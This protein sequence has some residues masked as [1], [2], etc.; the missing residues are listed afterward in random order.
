ML[1]SEKIGLVE[2]Y[3]SRY[4]AFD[5][6]GMLALLDEDVVFENESNGEITA[7]SDGKAEFE[8]L[9]SESVK[10]FSVRQQVV[11]AIEM[12]E[13]A[14]TVSIDYTGTLAIDL[15]NGLRAG[16]VLELKGQTYFEFQNGK[17][18]HI[19]DVS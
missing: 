6:S 3:V 8:S 12:F 4:N 13:R 14:A 17:I 5:V 16:Q 19:K 18:S 11:T 7:R 1:D 9:A 10:I 15:P 2:S